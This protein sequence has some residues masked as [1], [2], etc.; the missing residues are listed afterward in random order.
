M[1]NCIYCKK[2]KKEILIES[3]HCIAFYENIKAN[4]GNVLITTRKHIARYRDFSWDVKTEIWK[5]VDDITIYLE[6][7]FD[8][9]GFKIQILDGKSAGQTIEH[10]YVYII[11]TYDDMNKI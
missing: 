1:N 2:N 6:S 9:S 3:D 5:I 7:K 11:P 10:C 4:M 8:P